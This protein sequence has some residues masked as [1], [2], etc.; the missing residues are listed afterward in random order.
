MTLS[1]KIKITDS[2]KIEEKIHTVVE[3]KD[4]IFLFDTKSIYIF[5]T[6]NKSMNVVKDMNIVNLQVIDGDY[7]YAMANDCPSKNLTSGFYF[8]DLN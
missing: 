5:N 4:N 2:N 7:I 6:Q 3:A 8:Y 1:K